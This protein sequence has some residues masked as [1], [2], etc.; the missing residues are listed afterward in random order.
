MPPGLR[1]NRR[2]VRVFE[3]VKLMTDVVAIELDEDQRRVVEADAE[4]RLVVLAGAG[5]GKT[6]VVASRIAHLIDSDGLSASSEILVLS[7]S[8]AAVH[9]VRTRL[10]D[11]DATATANVRTFDSFASVLLLEEDQE[12]TGSFEQRIRQATELLRTAVD[13]PFLLDDLRH[14]ILDEVQDLVGD[15]AVFV[16]AVLKHLAG[17]AGFTVLGDPLQGIYDFVLDESENATTFNDV[18]AALE[19]DFDAQRLNLTG[20]YRARGEGPLRVAQA[21]N[22]L[23]SASGPADALQTLDSL[24]ASLPRR[25]EI[26]DWHFLDTYPGRS[27]VLCRSNADVMRVSR[28]M[29]AQGVR[30]VVRR[31]AQDFGAARWIAASLSALAGPVETRDAVESALFGAATVDTP[32]GAWYLLKAAEGDFRKYSQLNMGRL[33][34]RVGSGSV[35]LTLTQGDD[36]AITVSTVHRAKGLEFENVLIVDQRYPSDDEDQ[37]QDVRRRYVAL[38]RARD[39]VELV[40]IRRS[41]SSIRS[42]EWL[43][44]RLVESAG[45]MGKRRARAI[46]FRSGDVYSDRPVAGGN[47]DASTIQKTLADLPNGAIVDGV[48]DVELS[49]RERPVYSLVVDGNPIGRTGES[50]GDDFAKAFKVRRGVWPA[51]ISDLMLVSVETTTGDPRLS[52]QAGVGP[53]GFWLVPRVVGLAKPIWEVMERV[54]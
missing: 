4:A 16:L 5:Q 6:E 19:T 45:P 22:A 36:A 8:R 44:E 2:A 24:E 35:P 32:D 30:H 7:F 51:E 37:W 14:V 28:E 43:D 17:E 42:E 47:M 53:G 18:L 1:N 41:R 49:N 9:A 27:A 29:S 26:D 23:R 15:R 48:I 52:E 34:T 21:A 46:E 20:N 11:R 31:Q 40:D 10:A 12:P 25:S 13:T 39:N 38:S 54:G 50:F 33:R 3:R